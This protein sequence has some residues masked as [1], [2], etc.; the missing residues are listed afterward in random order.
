M[1]DESLFREVLLVILFGMLFGYLLELVFVLLLVDVE[2]FKFT[3]D[4]LHLSISVSLK[5]FTDLKYHKKKLVVR[6][7]ISK[8]KTSVRRLKRNL[9]TEKIPSYP[10]RQK[11]GIMR[12]PLGGMLFI[13]KCF[14]PCLY[15]NLQ[16]R[17]YNFFGKKVWLLI[18]FI[19]YF[20]YY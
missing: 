3:L 2:V 20:H 4:L 18:F 7:F 17:N 16:L 10:L 9:N 12:H 15:S 6:P 8:R 1:F 13:K 11:R 19:E 14:K 5:S